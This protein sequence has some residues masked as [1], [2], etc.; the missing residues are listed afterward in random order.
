MRLKS[1]KVILNLA[2]TNLRDIVKTPNFSKIGVYFLIKENKIIYVGKSIYIIDRLETHRRSKKRYNKVF[3]HYC[4]KENIDIL[5]S[6]YI[7]KFM[8]EENNHLNLSFLR[9]KLA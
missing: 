4:T 8:P 3:I 9:Q 5:E 6:K 7:Y 2:K 1:K